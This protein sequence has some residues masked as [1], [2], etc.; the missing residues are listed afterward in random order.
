MNMGRPPS[1]R[2]GS[3]AWKFGEYSGG[4]TLAAS[5][6]AALLLMAPV[7]ETFAADGTLSVVVTPR[8]ASGQSWLTAFQSIDALRSRWTPGGPRTVWVY[9]EDARGDGTTS[10]LLG[11]RSMAAD[12]VN[13]SQRIDAQLPVGEYLL[14]F[15]VGGDSVW[16]AFAVGCYAKATVRA[17]TETRITM[18][19]GDC[20]LET[21]AYTDVS[22]AQPIDPQRYAHNALGLARWRERC[23]T[24]SE[25]LAAINQ[26]LR[27]SPPREPVVFVKEYW[28][29]QDTNRS[30][31]DRTFFGRDADGA[32]IRRMVDALKY[33]CWQLD[34]G[35]LWINEEDASLPADEL[36]YKQRIRAIVEGELRN[37]DQLKAAADAL[38]R[39]RRR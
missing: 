37:L 7:A 38:D 10:H 22:A 29:A 13:P 18:P 8:A 15:V 30:W 23:A 12:S 3:R 4:T 19:A 20:T 14:H 26:R 28:I 2:R 24:L 39:A 34:W 21:R 9:A 33:W 1:G 27:A 36:G 11:A 6:L 32:Q 31:P 5:V 16:P 35:E 17:G 25:P